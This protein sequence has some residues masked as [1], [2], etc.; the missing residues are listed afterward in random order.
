MGAGETDVR[1]GGEHRLGGRS[2]HDLDIEAALRA[3]G[4]RGIS[5]LE[6]TVEALASR[7][8]STG[9]TTKTPPPGRAPPSPNR[10]WIPSRVDPL[11]C[12]SG[13]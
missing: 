2:S 10:A 9:T 3:S 8:G 11:V 7:E 6:R 1:L 12:G 5:F 4:K 13:I